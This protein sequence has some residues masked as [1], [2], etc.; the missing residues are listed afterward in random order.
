MRLD[1]ATGAA[2]PALSGQDILEHVPGLAAIAEVE[3]ED[4]SRLPGP[5]VTP[6]HMWR[7]AR[8]AAAWL[9]RPDV[10]GLV[11]THGTD[12]LEET[13]YLLDLLL[14]SPKPVVIVG[15]IRTISEAGWDGPANLLAAVRVAAAPESPGPRC[16]RGDERADPH[17]LGG[18][19]DP[20]RIGRLVRL[21]GVRPGRRPRRRQGALRAPRRAPWQL[22]GRRR[23]HGPAR[24]PSRNQRRP[25]Q[26]GGRRPT[27]ASC[28]AASPPAR[29]AS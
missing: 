21:A 11:V 24:R 1:P 29:P 23:R 14:L 9:E 10:Q 28:A 2:V 5:H 18:A 22:D 25:D 16:A 17:R 8:R 4:V 3:C 6:E 7:L 26:V 15:A 20:H 13:A 27:I 19:E 12:T